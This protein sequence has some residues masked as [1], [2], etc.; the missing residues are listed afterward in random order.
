MLPTPWLFIH[1]HIHS[2][3]KYVLNVYNVP[4]TALCPWIH[5]FYPP[6]AYGWGEKP[7]PLGEGNN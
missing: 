3:N 1:Y 6:Q 5:S 4:G 2:T 7:T